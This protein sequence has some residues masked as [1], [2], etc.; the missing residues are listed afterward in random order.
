MKLPITV[1]WGKLSIGDKEYIL[2]L[3]PV[4]IEHDHSHPEMT[5]IKVKQ[6]YRIIPEIVQ[7]AE[8]S[9]AKGD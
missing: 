6:R 9:D 7:L 8:D 4:E 2:E 3:P 5:T 1:S